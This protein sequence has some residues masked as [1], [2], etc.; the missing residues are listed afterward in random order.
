MPIYATHVVENFHPAAKVLWP[1][2]STI[3]VAVEMTN[4]I[5][6]L[7]MHPETPHLFRLTFGGYSEPPGYSPAPGGALRFDEI[8]AVFGDTVVSSRHVRIRH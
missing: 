5:P 1:A 2:G 6:A 7:S 3:A 8:V 4:Q